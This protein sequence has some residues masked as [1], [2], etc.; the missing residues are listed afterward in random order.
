MG[1]IGGIIVKLGLRIDLIFELNVLFK[2]VSKP[3]YLGKKSKQTSA[4]T[5]IVKIYM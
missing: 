4:I 2:L 5:K 1:L 3:Q